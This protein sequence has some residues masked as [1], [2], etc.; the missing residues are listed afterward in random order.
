MTGDWSTEVPDRDR[1]ALDPA[2]RSSTA[3]TCAAFTLMWGEGAEEDLVVV[4][5]A[6]G[7]VPESLHE[8]G[9]RAGSQHP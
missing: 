4:R 3:P 1:G 6:G 5:E 8:L 7:R 2:T 9:R